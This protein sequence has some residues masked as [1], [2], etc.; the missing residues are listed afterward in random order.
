MFITINESETLYN[1]LYIAHFR[2]DLEELTISYFLQ[3]GTELKE[4]FTDEAAMNTKFNL[5]SNINVGSGSSGG[6]SLVN[7][8][9]EEQFIG[10]YN[11][12]RLY[13]RTITG[14]F[15]QTYANVYWAN[16]PID[17]TKTIVNFGGAIYDT[18]DSSGNSFSADCGCRMVRLP[19]GALRLDVTDNSFAN[20]YFDCWVEYTKK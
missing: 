16:M 5:V 9:S 18:A 7:Y 17:G 14:I 11:G 4:K 6:T 8:T 13:R 12:D 20:K 19:S 3:N 2:K 15:D 10:Y 1:T